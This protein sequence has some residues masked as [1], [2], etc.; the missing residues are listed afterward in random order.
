MRWSMRWD[1]RAP[2]AR[3][4]TLD[5]E[6]FTAGGAT[7]EVSGVHSGGDGGLQAMRE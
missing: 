4:E 1:A 5:G 7:Q 6:V 3:S 2:L